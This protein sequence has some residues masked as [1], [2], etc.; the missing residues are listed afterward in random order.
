MGTG[1]GKIDK[2]IAIYEGKIENLF[3]NLGS[4]LS[5]HPKKTLAC[6]VFV[7]ILLSLGMINIT[8]QYDVETLYIPVNSKSVKDRNSIESLYEDPTGS[9][10]AAYQLTR[11]GLYADI[12]I[13]S[14]NNS[15]IMKQDYL[16]E[17]NFIDNYIRQQ[18]TTHDTGTHIYRY[19]NICAL[20][21]S[22]CE[23]VG[24]ILLSPQF[25]SDFLIRNV[26]FPVYNR[27][28]LNTLFANPVSKKWSFDTHGRC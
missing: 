2:C 21:L 12:L 13:M 19:E 17:I 4:F 6:C 28:S 24:G 26:T 14:K 3:T 11:Q 7:N 25:Q 22:G 8:F 15:S 23:V 20:G 10:F 16:T 9:N 5:K 27:V 18:I 1:N